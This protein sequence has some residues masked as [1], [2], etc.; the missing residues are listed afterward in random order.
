MGFGKGRILALLFLLTF[1]SNIRRT[2]ARLVQVTIF[3]TLRF[4]A[5]TV[6]LPRA[7]VA[8]KTPEPWGCRGQPRADGAGET[9]T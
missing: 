3:S 7:A 2:N 1:V 8:A 6:R 5:V 9:K 4:T